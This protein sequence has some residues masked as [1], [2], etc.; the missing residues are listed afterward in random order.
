MK[1]SLL[2]FILISLATLI[3]GQQLPYVGPD[4]TFIFPNVTN[5]FINSQSINWALDVEESYS[6]EDSKKIEDANIFKVIIPTY[7]QD[8]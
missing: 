6:F 3:Y 2:T 1:H 7:T 4:Q 5:Q 8:R